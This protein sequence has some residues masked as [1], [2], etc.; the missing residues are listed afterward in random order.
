L[1]SLPPSFVSPGLEAI[2]KRYRELLAENDCLSS[3][4]WVRL[5][6]LQEKFAGCCSVDLLKQF[7]C[8]LRTGSDG[9]WLARLFRETE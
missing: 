8:E 1:L 7:N 6:R 5:K 3:R 2:N 9:G 4:R